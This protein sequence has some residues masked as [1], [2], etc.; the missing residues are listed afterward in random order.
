MSLL[1]E[2]DYAKQLGLTLN[3]FSVVRQNPF[4]ALMRCPICGDSDKNKAKR[5][6]YI[7][8]R[9]GSLFY[10]C[11][12]CTSSTTFK[13]FIRNCN[14]PLADAMALASL[15]EHRG[16]NKP[17]DEP[18]YADFIVSRPAST[19]KS[20]NHT[21][22]NFDPERLRSLLPL[23]YCP[24]AQAYVRGRMIP[25]LMW[26]YIRYVKDFPTFAKD[27]LN[28][29][30]YE[31]PHARI[32]I[33]VID[34]ISRQFTGVCARTFYPHGDEHKRYYTLLGEHGVKV[35]IPRETDLTKRVWLTEGA[36]DAMFLPNGAAM[37][38]SDAALQNL[39]EFVP[40]FCVVLDNEPRNKQIVRRMKKLAKAGYR[41]VVWPESNPYKDINE[42]VKAGIAIDLEPLA[43]SGLEAVAAVNLWAKTNE[44]NNSASHQARR[45]VGRASP[46]ATTRSH[47]SSV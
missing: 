1:I 37:L 27:A 4:L 46:G 9:N 31:P 28:K 11:H 41:V 15:E 38:G 22:V 10:Y 2:I 5:R 32:V 43:V 3:R 21:Q 40:D 44:D 6:G 17:K 30:V 45:F 7:Y 18:K 14:E 8:E 26:K 24:E 25:E 16:F 35:W 13:R 29:T 12:N 33:P 23:S 47:Y 34:P 20:A 19:R 42:M 39:S 36:F